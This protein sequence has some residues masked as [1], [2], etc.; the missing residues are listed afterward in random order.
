[1][2]FRLHCLVFSVVFFLL[3]VGLFKGG[4]LGI[5][6]AITAAGTLIGILVLCPLICL[7]TACAAQVR[8]ANVQA[9]VMYKFNRENHQEQTL[10]DKLKGLFWLSDDTAPELFVSL[11][12]GYFDPVK[13]VITVPMGAPFNWSWSANLIG[14]LEWASVVFCGWLACSKIKFWF[15]DD[16]YKKATLKLYVC[17]CIPLYFCQE[18]T[19]EQESDENTWARNMF[20]GGGSCKFNIESWSYTLRRVMDENGKEL[21]EFQRMITTLKSATNPGIPAKDQNSSHIKTLDQICEGVRFPFL[22]Q[23]AAHVSQSEEP[24]PQQEAMEKLL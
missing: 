17:S 22:G 8:P 2:H 21:P 7:L 23:S 13:R 10:P 12:T 14:W 20:C 5:W 15:D 24:A 3:A 1:M 6:Q 11:E 9:E 16:S 19:M 4:G 18:W